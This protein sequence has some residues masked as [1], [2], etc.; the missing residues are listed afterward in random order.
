MTQGTRPWRV[1]TRRSA[2]ARA[3]AGQVADALA[4]ATGRPA[5]LV[6]LATTGDEHPDRAIEAFDR[7]GVFVDGTREAVLTGDCDVVV[8]SY[9]DL[10]TEQPEGLVVAA[11]PLRADPR[12]LLVTREGLTLSR[13]P[14]THPFSLGTSSNR[15]RA[16]IAKARR[17]LLIQPLRGNLDTRLRKVA[18]GDLDAVVVA[19]AGVQRM[20]PMEHDVRAVPLEPGE[21]LSA[22]AQGA[23]ALECRADDAE[24]RAALR[25]VDHEPTHVCVRAE[26]A[27]LA[28]LAGGCTAP[29]GALA[30][31]VDQGSGGGSRR[32]ELLGM[33]ADP[34]GSKVV[35]SSHQAAV[36][37]VGELG[38]TLAATLLSNGGDEIL[39]ALD[40]P[41]R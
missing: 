32:V 14:R 16:Q 36:T 30:S 5:E 34:N 41:D 13:I 40:R 35:R 26:R 22:P 20:G 15:R 39:A 7:K 18:D 31:I 12:D 9:K 11:V 25:L 17:D 6:P 38:R 27:M 28:A 33:V 24:T 4:E 21:V 23:L 29:I 37:Q 8:H 3:Q 1:A 19:L 2:L 10:P